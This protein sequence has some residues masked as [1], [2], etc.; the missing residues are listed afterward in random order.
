MSSS[1]RAALFTLVVAAAQPS[2]ADGPAKTGMSHG[3]LTVGDR[4][5]FVSDLAADAPCKVPCAVRPYLAEAGAVAGGLW[6]LIPAAGGQQWV[7]NGAPLFVW[8]EIGDARGKWYFG[9][10][11]LA[12]YYGP[13]A[14]LIADPVAE[15]FALPIGDPRV[16]T[17]P[18]IERKMFAK[19]NLRDFRGKSGT[20]VVTLCVDA[21]GNSGA[22]KLTIS[23]G[24]DKLDELAMD[25]V[26]VFP[27]LPAKMS[28]GSPVA[29]CGYE[30]IFDWPEGAVTPQS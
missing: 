11:Y 22:R 17:K 16:A 9:Y 2:F 27:F 1:F 3:A 15:G 23:S 21:D 20:A 29:V 4:L 18:A 12:E 26:R 8:P 6:T 19:Y 10:E 30:L 25:F 28:S 14:A 5:V 13:T 24:S 7:Y